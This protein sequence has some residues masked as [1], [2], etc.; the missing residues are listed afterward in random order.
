MD[1]I[2]KEIDNLNFQFSKKYQKLD[3]QDEKLFQR[4]YRG[5][6]QQGFSSYAVL[7]LL[8]DRRKK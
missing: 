6:T 2:E 4:A 1:S 8:K 7:D 5:L 3:L